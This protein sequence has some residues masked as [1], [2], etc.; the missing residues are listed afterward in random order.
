MISGC[1]GYNG[2]DV[3]ADVLDAQ[4]N[5]AS[6]DFRAWSV[7]TNQIGFVG[8]FPIEQEVIYEHAIVPE[9]ATMSLLAMGLIGMAG[10][11]LKRR[12]KTA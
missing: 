4:T 2:A 6:I 8:Q 7:I 11:G 5:Y 1:P 3:A 12:K 9:P 10:A